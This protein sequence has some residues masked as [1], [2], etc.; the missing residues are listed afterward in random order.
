MEKAPLLYSSFIPSFEKKWCPSGVPQLID[1]SIGTLRIQ[2]AILIDCNE[3]SRRQKRRRSSCR[4]DPR[5]SVQFVETVVEMSCTF[6]SDDQLEARL[7]S[8]QAVASSFRDS[9]TNQRSVLARI[10][11]RDAF[12]RSPMRDMSERFYREVQ[13]RNRRSVE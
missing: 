1:D 4:V 10:L 7:L 9:R 6:R 13:L 2:W 11:I 5:S 3:L 8:T 12:A